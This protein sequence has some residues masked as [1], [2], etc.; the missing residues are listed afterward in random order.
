MFDELI[1]FTFGLLRG[2]NIYIYIYNLSSIIFFF[3]FS[4]FTE[5]LNYPKMVYKDDYQGE[6]QFCD[7][8]K[9]EFP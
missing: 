5:N 8:R 7:Y 2:M 6:K 3:N 1:G 9:G 4:K